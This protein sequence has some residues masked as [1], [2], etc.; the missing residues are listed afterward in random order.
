[1]RAYCGDDDAALPAR[2]PVTHAERCALPTMV[3]VAEHE[4]PLLDV[5]G[6]EFAYRLAATR[7]RAPRFLQCRGHNHMSV[8]AH[9]GSGDEELGR[10]ILAFWARVE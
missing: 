10:E 5:Y 9:F 7:G 1:V 2:S 8:M 3:V 6:L 4:N